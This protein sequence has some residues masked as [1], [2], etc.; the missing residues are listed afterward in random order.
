MKVCVEEKIRHVQRPPPNLKM[1][2]QSLHRPLLA[3]G[4]DLSR[5]RSSSF[6]Q[7][8]AWSLRS[9]QIAGELLNA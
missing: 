4:L 3:S 5:P 1:M 7:Y 9:F 8:L 2:M 6:Q